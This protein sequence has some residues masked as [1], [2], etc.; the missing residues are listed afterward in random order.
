MRTFLFLVAVIARFCSPAFA[1]NDKIATFLRTAL[2]ER[3]EE[4]ALAAAEMPADKY[5]FKAPPDDITFGYLILH[6]ADGNYI[7][8]SYIGG[9]SAPELP[10]LTERD[11]KEKLMER[12]KSSFDFCE[13]ALGGLDDSHMKETL[14]ISDTKMSRAMAVLALTGSWVTHYEVQKRYLQLNGLRR[15]PG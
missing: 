12:M 11:S 3:S 6:I 7:F 2:N 9:V 14:T 15:G 8:C 10:Q 13:T 1:A 5:D 4:L